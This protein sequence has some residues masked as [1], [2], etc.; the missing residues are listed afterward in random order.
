VDSFQ[1]LTALLDLLDTHG[2]SFSLARVRGHSVM[3]QTAAP[4]ERWEIEVLGDGSVEVEFFTSDG[5]IYDEGK[6]KE[7][8]DRYAHLDESETQC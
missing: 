1:K 2:I 8:I 7:L 5:R 6:I 4:G 3:I